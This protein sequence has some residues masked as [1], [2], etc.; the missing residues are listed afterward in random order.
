[1]KAI[2]D[3]FS[4]YTHA[5][6]WSV[7]Y[8]VIVWAILHWLFNFDMFS[9]AHWTHVLRARLHGFPGFV[10][11]ILV[12]AAVPLYIATTTVIVRN[13]PLFEFKLLKRICSMFT[14]I[15]IEEEK[16]DDT[17]ADDTADEKPAN[18]TP[19]KIMPGEIV[20]A[21]ERART[22]I[23][24]MS[25]DFD[26][27][28]TMSAITA[29]DAVPQPVTLDTPSA[30]GIVDSD[31]MPLPTDFDI[32]G[33]NMDGMNNMGDDFMDMG[34]P[35]A[36]PSFTDITFGE[37]EPTDDIPAPTHTPSNNAADIETFLDERGIK[38]VKTD[39]D[40]IMTDKFAIASHTD[41]DFWVVDNESW[42]AAGKQK[43]S[44]TGAV[45][46]TA[47]AHGLTPV[48]YLGADNIMDIEKHRAKWESDG[49]MIITTPSQLP[50]G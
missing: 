1:M 17:P 9:M 35:M 27:G 6:L 42:F 37:P 23:S 10:F 40:I 47:A 5:I 43:P 15:M 16:P 14:P 46:T 21:Y 24:H 28:K 25:S 29:P 48:L 49:I 36:M 33:D 8:G 7:A 3:F 20:G 41:D 18:D 13:G 50:L 32:G 39:D 19:K 30:S 31:D 22:H 12:L 34:M 44:P 38:T 2:F 45:I 26:M 4:K 11:G